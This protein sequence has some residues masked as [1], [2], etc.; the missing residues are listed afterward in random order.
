MNTTFDKLSG[1]KD[2]TVYVREVEVSDLPSEL[3]EQVEGLT[4]IFS[5]HREDGERLALVA[6]K[7]LAFALARE[8][9]FAPVSVH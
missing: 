8:H 2:R 4:Q 7:G 1:A 6:N 3:R 5:V 9:D